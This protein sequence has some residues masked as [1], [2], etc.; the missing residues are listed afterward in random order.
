MRDWW[1]GGGK[2]DVARSEH[3]SEFLQLDF[4]AASFPVLARVILTTTGE[5]RKVP[6]VKALMAQW[7]SDPVLAARNRRCHEAYAE[8]VTASEALL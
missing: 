1:Q 6:A 5:P 7:L 2:N 3:L 4:S 8:I